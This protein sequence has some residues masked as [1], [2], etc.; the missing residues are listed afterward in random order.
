M[1]VDKCF[2]TGKTGPAASAP[3]KPSLNYRRHLASNDVSEQNEVIVLHRGVGRH[4]AKVR[5]IWVFESDP[6]VTMSTS[7]QM[8]EEH[9]TQHP[10]SLFLS[11]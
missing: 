2:K 11:C 5:E 3:L 9:F 4:W 8:E 7:T 1:I 6:C 10:Q